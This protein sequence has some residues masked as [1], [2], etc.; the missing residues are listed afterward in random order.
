MADCLNEATN[1]AEELEDRCLI[2]YYAGLLFLTRGENNQA[3]LIIDEL[4]E[5]YTSLSTELKN[6]F[7]LLKAKYSIAVNSSSQTI[8]QDFENA[9]EYARKLF[10]LDRFPLAQTLYDYGA[11]LKDNNLPYEEFLQE[12]SEIFQLLRADKIQKL[13]LADEEP[14]LRP[15]QNK[16]EYPTN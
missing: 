5:N 8:K 6:V 15:L 14:Q 13:S 7:H 11:W 3:R 10:E 2:K 16:I 12:A 9:I 1:Y 4:Q